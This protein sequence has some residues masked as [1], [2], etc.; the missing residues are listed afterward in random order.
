MKYLLLALLVLSH[1]VAY[2]SGKE[3]YCA[4][5]SNIASNSAHGIKQGVSPE[6]IKQDLTTVI[7]KQQLTEEKTKEDLH[8][9][10]EFGIYMA[11]NS[12]YDPPTIGRYQL[13]GCW[14]TL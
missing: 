3:D 13:Y 9:A 12:S 7:K 5:L 1:G 11:L 8:R 4:T 14:M 2:A 6:K 10:S